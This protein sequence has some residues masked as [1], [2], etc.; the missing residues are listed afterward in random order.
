MYFLLLISIL[1]TLLWINILYAEYLT[2]KVNPFE[3]QDNTEDKIRS[4][5][6]I[7]LIII[8]ALSWSALIYLL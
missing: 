8:M 5:I 1:S 3:P 7:Y 4:K 2:S 6:K